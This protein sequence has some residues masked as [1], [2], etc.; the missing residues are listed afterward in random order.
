MHDRFQALLNLGTNIEKLWAA[1]KQ[2]V[3]EVTEESIGKRRGFQR[4]TME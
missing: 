4:E 1:F 2:T 3:Q